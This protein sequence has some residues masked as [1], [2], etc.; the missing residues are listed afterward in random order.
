M[1]LVCT[2]HDMITTLGSAEEEGKFEP[3]ISTQRT[4]VKD[5]VFLMYSWGGGGKGRW[6]ERDLIQEA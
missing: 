1:P 2:W 3:K 6:G 4:L 5:L